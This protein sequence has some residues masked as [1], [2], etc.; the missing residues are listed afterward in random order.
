MRSCFPTTW[1]A[2]L[3]PSRREG[4]V[5]ALAVLAATFVALFI[6]FISAFAYL[7]GTD[8]YFYAL[9]A[10]SVLDFGHLKVPDHGA[11]PYLIAGLAR[12]GLTVEAAF[13]L[14]ISAVFMLYQLGMLFL[15]LRLKEWAQLLAAVLWALSCPLI[16]FHTVEFPSLTLGVATLPWWFWLAVNPSRKR[17]FW[18]VA[19][20]AANA[21]V[22]P[23]AAAF[24]FLFVAT[25]AIGQVWSQRGWLRERKVLVLLVLAVCTLLAVAVAAL[26]L[27]LKGRLTELRP[28]LPGL[29]GV[30]RSAD[31]P[32]EVTFTVTSAWLLLLTTLVIYIKARP[33]RWTFLA[34]AALALPLWPDHESGLRGVGGR[35][36]VLFVLLAFPLI[37][38]L[39]GDLQERSAFFARWSRPEMQVFAAISVL[40][41]AALLPLRLQAYHEVLLPDDYVSYEKVVASLRDIKVPMLIAHR[42]LDFFYSYRLRRDAFHFDPE[43][44]WNRA[45]IWR[46]AARITPE[47]VA[48][49]SPPQCPWGQTAWAIRGT[50]Y[51]LVRE[52]CWEQLRSLVTRDENPDL[53][54]EI[55]TDMENPSQT[56][57]DFLRARNQDLKQG[58][59]SPPNNQ[60]KKSH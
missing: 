39:W 55:W 4:H 60:G 30:V 17:I 56:R 10:Q 49:Y 8:A 27:D 20:L 14:V 29:L 48:Y 46:V 38:A 28:G 9:Q 59:F 11:V 1:V 13:R 57:P 6:H 5:V 19:L 41:A 2:V 37:V 23:A 7:P 31:T 32:R 40:I 51:V 21:A 42:G 36:A 26:F 50:G 34:L 43:P 35:L 47:E 15:V 12:L 45:E 54:T 33:G 53:Y 3:R 22:H 24:V 18:L 25:L 52:D 58:P 16:A 44:N